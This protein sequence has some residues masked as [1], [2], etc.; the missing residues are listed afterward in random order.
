MILSH[1]H[2]GKSG[3]DSLKIRP[4]ARRRRHAI[5]NVLFHDNDSKVD[6]LLSDNRTIKLHIFISFL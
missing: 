5:D 1:K 2:D 3:K 6:P 4:N